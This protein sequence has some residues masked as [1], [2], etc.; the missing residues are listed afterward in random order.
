MTS[1]PQT[2]GSAGP[3]QCGRTAKEGLIY[4]PSC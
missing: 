1:C 2:D 3:V 4:E